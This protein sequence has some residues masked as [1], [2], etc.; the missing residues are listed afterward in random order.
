MFVGGIRALLLQSLHPVAMHAVHG[1]SGFRGDPW[2]RLQRTS[3]F[4][5][6]TTFG[7]AADAEEM[8]ARINAI[9]AGVRGTTADGRPYAANDPHLLAWVHAAEV[10]SFLR[11][12]QTYGSGELDDAGQD[13]YVADT[14]EVAT[15][16]GVLDP[17][18]DRQELADCLTSYRAE[19]R[20]T[21]EAR[22]AARFL[23]LT[24]PVPTLLRPGYGLLA[25][26]AVG[27]MP[28]W[29]RWPLRLPYLPVVEAT[30]VRAAGHAVTGT[31]RWGMAAS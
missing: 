24:P 15:R 23:L 2:G 28:R 30:A 18:R 5:A 19:L 16:L 4:L 8:V 9:H 3:H 29:T 31:I 7:S 25:S 6:V 21:P 27:L 1:H 26:A 14:A 11:A 12:Y 13:Q 20:G 17:P 10:D 22:S